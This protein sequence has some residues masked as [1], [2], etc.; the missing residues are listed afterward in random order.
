MTEQPLRLGVVGLGRAFTLMLPTFVRHPAVRLVACADPRA[1][2]RDCFVHDFGGRAHDTVQA[3]CDDPEVEAI[4]LASPHQFHVDHVQIAARAGKHVL[5]EK[6][7]ALRLE[8]CRAMIASAD[9]AGV[10]LMVGHSHSFDQPY[11]TTRALIESGEFGAVRMISALNC[12]DYLYR[13]RRPE[14][15]VTAEGGGAVFS[16]APHQVELVRLL[17]GSE[18]RSVRAVTGI[19][20]SE[21]PTEGAYTAFLT[22]ANGAAASLTYNGY[23]H[24][25]TDALSSWIGE[26]GQVRDPDGHGSARRVLRTVKMAAEEAALKDKRAYG[27]T[28]T[29]ATARAQTPPV[30]YNHFGF[31]LVACE[32]GALRPMPNGVEIYGDD[33]KRF[34]PLPAPDVPRR[35]VIDELVAAVRDGRPPLHSGRWGMATVEVCLALLRSAAEER[36]V[37]I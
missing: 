24:F 18:V 35:E 31:V 11:L 30:A 4:Y 22:F 12:T 34:E 6:P 27:T 10:H 3:L 26:M 36:E 23:G 5:V 14:E 20:D 33:E 28:V 7:M 32:R 16:Q 19:W 1:V 29:A 13:P 25:D 15:L 8:D 9:A 21:R 2:A 37:R 17:A